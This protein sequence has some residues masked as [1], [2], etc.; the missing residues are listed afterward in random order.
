MTCMAREPLFVCHIRVEG[1]PLGRAHR[2]QGERRPTSP[3]PHKWICLQARR[4]FSQ[5]IGMTPS[6]PR[7]TVHSNLGCNL[8]D[9]QR[10]SVRVFQVLSS[11]VQFAPESSRRAVRASS[12]PSSFSAE[13][14][15]AQLSPR[16]VV[17]SFVQDQV[18]FCP[19]SSDAIVAAV[20]SVVVRSGNA[21]CHQDANPTAQ[22]LLISLQCC[23]SSMCP[24]VSNHSGQAQRQESPHKPCVS[25]SWVVVAQNQPRSALITA[26]C[27]RSF[28]CSSSSA[29]SDNEIIDLV[30]CPLVLRCPLHCPD[31]AEELLRYLHTSILSDERVMSALVVVIACNA[32]SP[33]LCAR[34]ASPVTSRTCMRSNSSHV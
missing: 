30:F 2:G 23:H 8:T 32:F 10:C 19:P 24:H 25:Q 16:S 18:S 12:F 11:S 13:V 20:S 6:L 15:R 22:M 7:R 1:F 4:P 29:V 34:C 27:I 3:P 9:D 17:A 26:L 33:S 28:P 14:Q 21:T 5:S 31:T